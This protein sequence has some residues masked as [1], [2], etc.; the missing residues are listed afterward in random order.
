MAASPYD[1][2]CIL[3]IH[4]MATWD[5]NFI[6][7]IQKWIVNALERQFENILEEHIAELKKKLLE[8]KAE[9]IWSLIVQLHSQSDPQYRKEILLLDLEKF[10]TSK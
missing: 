10:L 3:K 2:G 1:T 4:T 5:T 9:I 7:L 8:R 6:P